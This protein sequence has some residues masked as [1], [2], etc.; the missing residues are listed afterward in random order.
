M[1]FACFSNSA[2]LFFHISALEMRPERCHGNVNRRSNGRHLNFDCGLAK[3]LD[4]SRAHG[5]AAAHKGGSLAVPLRVNPI[6]CIF[7]HRGGAIV[8]FRRDEYK[9]DAAIWAVHFLTTS[10]S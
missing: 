4:G 8:V 1:T 6:D 9:S 5:A 10:C 3:L 7:Q 2:S